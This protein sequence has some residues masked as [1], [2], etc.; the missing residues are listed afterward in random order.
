MFE[1]HWWFSNNMEY[2]HTIWKAC[3]YNILC[4]GL[5]KGEK[6]AFLK[7]LLCYENCQ[8][9]KGQGMQPAQLSRKNKFLCVTSTHLSTL[10]FPLVCSKLS[11]MGV[12]VLG[13]CSYQYEQIKLS[14]APKK[15]NYKTKLTNM[16]HILYLVLPICSGSLQGLRTI[17]LTKRN[18]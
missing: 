11:S 16:W 9:A 1:N 2:F 12:Y 13:L 5:W 8:H 6:L 7:I 17:P 10:I 14:E 4:G 3:T 15:L 18:R